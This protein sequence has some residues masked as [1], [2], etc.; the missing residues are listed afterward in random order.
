MMTRTQIA[1]ANAESS[2]ARWTLYLIAAR[3]AGDVKR[4]R[5]GEVRLT[6]A[7]RRLMDW[8]KP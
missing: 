4:I 3:E 1:K 6:N 5:Y 2:V 8:K 7:R